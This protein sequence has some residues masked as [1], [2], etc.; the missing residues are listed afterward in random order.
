MMKKNIFRLLI[1]SAM[2]IKFYSFFGRDVMLPIHNMLIQANTIN[3]RLQM[4]KGKLIYSIYL[5]M[6]LILPFALP[7]R[8]SLYLIK[9]NKNV[10]VT[11]IL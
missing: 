3:K 1:C 7:A 6:A 2:W 11:N 4:N 10:T 5:S 9:R 8:R